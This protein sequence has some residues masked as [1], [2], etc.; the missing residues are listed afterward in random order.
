[1]KKQIMD[2]FM[3][4]H[5]CKEFDVN[6]RI[7]EKDFAFILEAA[8][9]SPSSF[10][11]EPWEFHI[12]QNYQLRDK[13]LPLCWGGS[14]QFPTASHLLM[15]LTKK[16]YFMRFNSDYIIRIM[17]NI[18]NISDEG[19]ELRKKKYERFQKVD[20]KL[21]ENERTLTD[22]AGK[23]TY[24]AMANMMTAAAFIGI[25]SCPIEG[26]DLEKTEEIIA[27]EMHIDIEKYALSYFL[28]FGYRIQEPVKK[29]RQPIN[30]I[31]KWYK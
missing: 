2:A 11:F 25:D 15:C 6:K 8:R 21:L 7:S 19:I 27:G 29:T 10:G 17:K 22:W 30:D 9:L 23:Q 13:L 31:V 1:M 18:K 3:F 24:I 20:L 16:S 28:A 12:I 5:A 4:R 26:F 14:K